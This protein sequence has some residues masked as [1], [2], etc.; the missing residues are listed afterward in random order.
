MTKLVVSSGFEI[1][2]RNY[3]IVRTPLQ[4]ALM[5]I[6][7]RRSSRV[8]PKPLGGT[9]RLVHGFS[10]T[11]STRPQCAHEQ[12][13]RAPEFSV[14]VLFVATGGTRSSEDVE[15]ESTP[16]GTQARYRLVRSLRLDVD[17]ADKNPRVELQQNGR[18]TAF[19]HFLETGFGK[20]SFNQV[21]ESGYT[22]FPVFPVFR[23]DGSPGMT[24]EALTSK[25]EDEFVRKDND[26]RR[27][28]QQGR[29]T[30]IISSRRFML[31]L[32]ERGGGFYEGEVKETVAEVVQTI[33][34]VL[35]ALHYGCDR[36][37]KV[38]KRTLLMS[39]A[40][41][42]VQWLH[43]DQDRRSVQKK[44][45]GSNKSSRSGKSIP[46]PPPYSAVCAFRD[47]VYLHVVKGSQ[48]DLERETFEWADATEVEVPP[49]H[50]ILFHSC[51]AHAGASYERINGRLHIYLSC[52]GDWQTADGSFRIVQAEGDG[53]PVARESRE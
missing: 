4:T 24:K 15:A 19:N 8:N 21:H 49:G 39:P 3:E 35:R 6:S 5:E 27:E 12:L 40:G 41:S 50:A 53:R 1:L 14:D 52:E 30:G 44:L 37:V 16:S 26:G 33:A 20:N 36:A 31:D 42:E 29:L 38:D 51:L 45:E 7:S 25:I 9:K 46:L 23:G 22:V 18:R 28:I 48:L 17:A 2:P 13:V 34:T 11:C 43:T 32:D 10:L 47:T